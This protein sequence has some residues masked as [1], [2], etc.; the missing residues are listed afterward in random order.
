VLEKTYGVGEF[1]SEPRL[2]AERAAAAEASAVADAE[3][4][5]RA[6]ET[7][8]EKLA[9]QE[10]AAAAVEQRSITRR[11]NQQAAGRAED[12]KIRDE[13][14]R[15][16]AKAALEEVPRRLSQGKDPA[17]VARELLDEGYG[18]F[19]GLTGR[20]NALYSHFEKP[21]K[22]LPKVAVDIPAPA[23][24]LA[25]DFAMVTNPVLNRLYRAAL[26]EGDPDMGPL[27]P[28]TYPLKDVRE[29]RKIVRSHIR[30]LE[31]SPSGQTK[32]PGARRLEAQLTQQMDKWGAKDPK[33]A[34]QLKRL[35]ALDDKYAETVVKIR[36]EFGAK[37][38]RKE[39]FPRPEKILASAASES[40]GPADVAR[41][42]EYFPGGVPRVRELLGSMA[43]T[44]P[45]MLN[46]PLARQVLTPEEQLNIRGLR[47]LL[48]K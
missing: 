6:A 9:R 42:K 35:K 2:K 23:G 25:A 7:A 1:V 15:A 11:M 31:R 40:R 28:N 34:D 4:A 3:A 36:K 38:N 16:S 5:A 17:T 10:K 26:P 13:E 46:G 8:A 29:A 27:P 45:G 18:A 47:G 21:R 32:L 44:K 30:D 20:F 33:A 12:L 48:E 24:E 37:G 43:E 41:V 22:G 39:Q 14:I 19:E